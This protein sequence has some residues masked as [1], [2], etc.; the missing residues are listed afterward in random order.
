MRTAGASDEEI[1]LNNLHMYTDY[2]MYILAFNAAGDGPNITRAVSNRTD[3]GSK[4]R[5]FS[6]QSSTHC[7]LKLYLGMFARRA[8]VRMLC[9]AL[10]FA[11]KSA[12]MI[13]R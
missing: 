10:M 7:F 6:S 3:E 8:V 13:R 4:S 12:V 1:E 2:S 5:V 9:K 11:L